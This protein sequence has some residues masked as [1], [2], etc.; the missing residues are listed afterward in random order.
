MLEFLEEVVEFKLG[1][2]VHSVRKPN[3]GEIKEYTREL[4]VC[5][6]DEDKEQAL[7]NLLEKL[8][9]KKE[10]FEKLNPYQSKKLLAALYDSEK[11]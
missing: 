3:N 1:E 7:I 9:L 4:T 2:E 11:N 5:E 10:V 8:G 6:N